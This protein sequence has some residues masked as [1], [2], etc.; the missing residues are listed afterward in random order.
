LNIAASFGIVFPIS[1]DA[2]IGSRYIQV[3]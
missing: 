2:K 3:L 1:S